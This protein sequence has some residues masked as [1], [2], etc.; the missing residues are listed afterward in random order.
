MISVE[1]VRV[2]SRGN[3]GGNPLGVVEQTAALDDTRMQAIAA[4]LGFSETTFITQ[5]DRTP[6]FVR[7]FT[8]K[9]ELAFA[10]HP[11]VG[12]AWVL[13]VLRRRA[14]PELECGMGRVQTEI[15]GDTSWIRLPLDQSVGA[16][17][18]TLPALAGM[19][20]PSRAWTVAMPRDYLLFE[21]E[22]ADQISAL[23]PKMS[24]LGEHFL[25]HAFAR[26]GN[27]VRARVF[28][29][30]AGVPEDPATGSAAVALAAVLQA[31]GQDAGQ[32]EISQGDEMGC[33]S[34]IQL[35]WAAGQV[36]IG[37]TVVQDPARQVRGGAGA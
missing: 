26:S 19:P 18:P 11:L 4:E 27:Q 16:G 3:Q 17:N 1:V 15:R 8:P 32:I 36:R 29:P 25:I 7:I 34:T 6:P 5:S 37:G 35:E 22:S 30:A 13:G 10:G 14:V 31:E 12:T 20:S 24:V 2:F 21:F 23:D 28:A 33:P 9:F